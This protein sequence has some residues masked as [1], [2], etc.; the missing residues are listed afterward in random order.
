MSPSDRRA[1]RRCTI[2]GAAL[3]FYLLIAVTLL[4][5]ACDRPTEQVVVYTSVDQAFAEP[6]LKRFEQETGISTKAA[7]D[8]EASKTVGLE[9]RLLA[10]KAEPRAD[11][12]WNSE[13][14]RTLRLKTAGILTPYDSPVGKHI[15]DGF[16]DPDGYW[17]GFGA[18]Y[19]VFVVNNARLGNNDIPNKLRDLADPRWK[20]QS[21]IAKPFFGTTSTHFAALY[22]RWGEP[23]YTEFMKDLNENEIT[24]LTGNSHVR[25]AVVRGE[26]L[27]GLTDTDDVSVALE[28]GDGVSMVMLDQEADG[29]YA[30]PHTV[31]LIAGGP[32]PENGR[33]LIDYLLSPEVVMMLTESGAVHGPIRPNLEVTTTS[34]Q[35]ERIWQEGSRAI[36]NALKPSADI[37]RRFLAE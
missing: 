16:R 29:A 33:K 26:Y 17:T 19:R 6:V 36:L 22:A 35:P 34:P 12:F 10:E 4:I 31:S 1:S 9:K 8:T 13:H 2:S 23:A 21:A 14:L 30:I 15:P 18:R 7:Y 5:T 37:A 20:G 27:F 3:P 28:R 32:N 25:D 11:V 24:L